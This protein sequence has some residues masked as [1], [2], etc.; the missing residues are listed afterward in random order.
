[1]ERVVVSRPFL[2]VCSMQVCAVHDATDKEILS[3]S[4]RDNVCG[5]KHGWCDVLREGSVAEPVACADYP[6]RVHFVVVC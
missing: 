5:T 3:V 4:N 6:G 2:G 1:M